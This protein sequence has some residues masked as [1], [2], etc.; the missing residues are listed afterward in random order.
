MAALEDSSFGRL[1]GVL[2][3]PAKTFRSIAERPTWVVV[4][5]ILALLGSGIGQLVNARTDQRKMIEKQMAKFGR[6][7]TPEQLEDAVQRAKNP[8]PVLRAV[9]VVAGLVFQVLFAYLLPTLLFFVVFKLAGS[10]LT[11]KAALSTY[12][13]SSVPIMIGILL[14]IPVVL[15]RSSVE[16]ADALTGRLLASSPAFFLPEGASLVLRGALSAFD[17]FNLWS[18][19]LVIVG[20][21]IVARVSTTAATAAAVL[22]FLLGMGFRAGMAAFLG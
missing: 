9:S 18:V 15:S 1:I 20:Y 3:S 13:H 7:L 21:R 14:S 2:A 11:F 22:L 16:P 6:Q 19:A 10:D 8:P 5:V 17:V 4:L 12:L